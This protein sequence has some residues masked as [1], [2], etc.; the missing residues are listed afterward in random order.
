MSVPSILLK[1][2]INIEPRLAGEPSDKPCSACTTLSYFACSAKL[3]ISLGEGS[4]LKGDAWFGTR[5]N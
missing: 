2:I 3:L 1:I 4:V 5:T